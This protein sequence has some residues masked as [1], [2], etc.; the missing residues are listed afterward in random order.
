MQMATP[1]SQHVVLHQPVKFTFVCALYSWE[2]LKDSN[3]QH[4]GLNTRDTIVSKRRAQSGKQ[5]AA[6]IKCCSEAQQN[7]N[8]REEK[9]V[10]PLK[11]ALHT[12]RQTAKGVGREA[13]EAKQAMEAREEH[14]SR[15]ESTEGKR[16]RQ[17]KRVAYLGSVWQACKHSCMDG[18]DAAVNICVV[19]FWNHMLVCLP[20]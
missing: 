13:E 9:N 11:G 10:I 14:N 1:N 8:A 5:L 12:T 17:K 7:H 19:H 20:A 15:W 4:L 3:R 18:G 6:D 16:S 2:Q